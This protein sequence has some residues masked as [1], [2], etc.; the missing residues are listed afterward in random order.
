[1]SINHTAYDALLD[2]PIVVSIETKKA[3]ADEPIKANLQC[4]V[5]HIAQ[6]RMLRQL[7][8][9]T[10]L[11]SLPFLPLLLVHGHEW[12]F[13]ATSCVRGKIILWV[14]WPIGTTRDIVGVYQIVYGIQM[15]AKWARE[16]YWPWFKKYVLKLDGQG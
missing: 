2:R 9:P 3:Q 1:M 13:A 6:W 8:P 14:E 7:V 11:D 4:S 10:A 12:Y 5:W 16:I 15:L